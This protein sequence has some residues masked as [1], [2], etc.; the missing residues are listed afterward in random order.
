M[1]AS[2]QQQAN[3]SAEQS[4]ESPKDSK[5]VR[6]FGWFQHTAIA[7]FAIFMALNVFLLTRYGEDKKSNDMFHGTGSMD[8]A[9][10][11]F[12]KLQQQPRVVL[13][14][15][16]LMMYPFW[17]L[18]K[19][20]L[21]AQ[22]GDMFHQRESL[23]LEQLLTK[24]GQPKPIVYSFAVFGQMVSD[25]YLYVDQFLQGNKK[26][27]YIVYG[28]A[29]RDFHDGDLPAPMT[30]YSFKR[31]V[32]ISNFAHY[33]D[34][35][36]PSFQEKADFLAGKSCFF[37]G[38]RWNL[39]HEFNRAVEKLYK[40]CGITSDGAAKPSSDAGSAFSLYGGTEERWKGS[41]SEYS[42]RYRNID[43]SKDV[44]LQMGFLQ[45][46]LSICSQREIKVILVNM[47][48][49][50]VNRELMPP[51]FYDQYTQRVAR[52]A[53]NNGAQFIDLGY[54]PEFIHDDYWDTTHLHHN[55]GMKML[56]YLL[57]VLSK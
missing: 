29:P 32:N 48:L 57:P 56:K 40:A 43:T 18:D 8:Y 24:P 49:T 51:G 6:P 35:Y 7:A 5:K 14:G 31:L 27:E 55:G 21:P 54:A 22:T 15:S 53:E 2:L 39:Q 52:V 50:D 30:T 44:D 4:N 16:S 20:K 12:E 19:F 10:R 41:L 13:L 42:R 33:A 23:V 34:L 11:T 25:A 38:H 37:F 28:I 3:P 36:L 26:P 1:P 46:L 45:K 47:P 17:A 9:V